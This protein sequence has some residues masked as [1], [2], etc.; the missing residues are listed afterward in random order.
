MELKIILIFAAFLFAFYRNN[1]VFKAQLEINDLITRTCKSRVH[2]LYAAQSMELFNYNPTEHRS[3]IESS[4]YSYL[5]MMIYF[6]IWDINKM[7][8]DGTRKG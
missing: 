5:K 8:N 4:Y 2:E 6:W 3:E 7:R 1:W